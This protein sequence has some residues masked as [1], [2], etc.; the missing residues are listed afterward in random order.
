MSY[1]STLNNLKPKE[2]D[3]VLDP[4]MTFDYAQQ[5]FEHHEQLSMVMDAIRHCQPLTRQINMELAA[6]EQFSK[7]GSCVGILD[8]ISGGNIESFNKRI[9]ISASDLFGR[10]ESSKRDIYVSSLT[11]DVTNFIGNLWN[12]IRNA[13]QKVYDWGTNITN[14]EGRVMM[15]KGQI[16][17][18]I[19]ALNAKGNASITCD[20]TDPADWM[21][22][23]SE[24]LK[25]YQVL[26]EILT[27]SGQS[28]TSGQLTENSLQDQL[29]GKMQ[30]A[31]IVNIKLN[32]QDGHKSSS[33]MFPGICSG[34]IELNDT[35]QT[36]SECKQILEQIIGKINE[37][38]QALAA[39]AQNITTAQTQY[40]CNTDCAAVVSN[41]SSATQMVTKTIV[42]VNSY[43]VETISGGLID[44]GGK[45][46]GAI[47]P[48][49]QQ[50]VP[51]EQTPAPTQQPQDNQPQQ[52]Q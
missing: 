20:M 34:R 6:I 3:R 14:G 45:I 19:N 28:I 44:I 18:A 27:T 30:R 24:C 11:E 8:I 46:I 32:I 10:S 49:P 51:V 47:G 31:S 22:K 48:V 16:D 15:A 35:A 1:F 25:L 2:E 17:N 21:A 41:I 36:L 26:I 50:Q 5:L 33:F 52:G 43:V 29:L 4:V 38:N 13:I 39:Y 12:A 42:S 9:G 37:L 23:A 40:K 7:G